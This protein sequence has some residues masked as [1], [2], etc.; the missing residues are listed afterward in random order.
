MPKPNA[1][2][3]AVTSL[4]PSF[5]TLMDRETP[6]PQILAVG[7]EDGR[8]GLLDMA[9]P[10]S[11]VWASI[12]DSLRQTRRVAYVEIDQETNLITQLLLPRAVRVGSLDVTATGDVLVELIIS[13]AAALPAACAPRLLRPAASSTGRS[14][15]WIDSTGDGDPG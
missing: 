14:G 6:P 13:T 9:A 12:L 10:S 1:V 5:E 15:R 4:S 3:N 8:S 11:R 2:V 7:F